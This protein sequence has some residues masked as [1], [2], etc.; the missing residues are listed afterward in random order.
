MTVAKDWTI[1]YLLPDKDEGTLDET[2]K[3]I[4]PQS[5]SNLEFPVQALTKEIKIHP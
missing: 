5:G 3:Q 2:F 4:E 1:E